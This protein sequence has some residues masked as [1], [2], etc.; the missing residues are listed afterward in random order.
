LG[1]VGG[2]VVGS[3][4]SR[5]AALEQS[6]PGFRWGDETLEAQPAAGGI[7]SRFAT[8]LPSSNTI[9][10]EM[11]IKSLKLLARPKRFELLTPRVVV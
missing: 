9:V 11:N 6:G 1:G 7:T 5:R 10:A 4:R 3:A 8:G 2:G